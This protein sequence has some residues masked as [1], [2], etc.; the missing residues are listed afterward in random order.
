MAKWGFRR[1][2]LANRR[3]AK[4]VL[5]EFI[6][7]LA[8]RERQLAVGEQT[9]AGCITPGTMYVFSVPSLIIVFMLELTYE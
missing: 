7:A 3:L 9:G 6:L 5:C 2:C 4:G 8:S 1:L